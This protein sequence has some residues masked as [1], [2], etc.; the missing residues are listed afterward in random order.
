M[1]RTFVL[2]LLGLF[3]WVGFGTYLWSPMGFALGPLV[4][5]LLVGLADMTQTRHAIRRNFPFI[6]H[7]RYLLEK[8]RPE[9][10]QYFVESNTDGRPFSRE[11]RSVVYQRAKGE[12][13]TVPFGTQL[14]L[15]EVGAE[16]L[17]HSLAPRPVPSEAP[18]IL[19]GEKQCKQP[20]SA[21]MLNVSAMSYGSLSKNAILALSRGAKAGGFAHNTGEGGVSDYHREGGADL[22]WQLGTG[23]F[24]C[25]NDDGTF[26][27]QL[28][29]E[30]A[31]TPQI[32]MIEIKLSQGAKP[33]HGG[34]LPASKLTPEI[35]R[36]RRVKMGQDVLS[37][38]AHSAFQTPLQ[39]VAFVDKL[40]EL[41]GGKPVGLKICIGQRREFFALCKAMVLTGSHPDYIQVDGAEGGTGAAPLEFSNS[42]GI[43]LTDALI[44][45]HNALVGVGLRNDIKLIASGKVLTGFNMARL[46]AMGA[47]MCHSARA[48]MMALGCIQ[49][50][51]CNSND[52][53]TGVAT[54]DPDLVY[55]L[56]VRDKAERVARY[57]AETMHSF[58]E[59]VAACGVDHPE[60]LKPRNL[61]RRVSAT[62]IRTYAQIYHYV[63]PG[64]LERG[65]IPEDW[66]GLWDWASAE[67]FEPVAPEN[68][69]SA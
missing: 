55:G 7:A 65:E 15:Y 35:A 29:A 18:R 51:R 62:E 13:D 14:D 2:T 16:W 66:K 3:A 54:Q 64:C 61:H 8:V 33:A 37:P 43:P 21:S 27:E 44:F 48:M 20:Y 49:A 28:F 9:I 34:I 59:L 40:R 17:T 60:Q 68:A 24:G 19:I 52:C 25:R 53:P 23:Y 67:T 58:L 6:G 32:K 31:R 42:L 69:R 10:N 50:R 47:D 5:V 63:A 39:L 26:S 36:I 57:H 4:L 56:D 1:R 30:T 12:L 38:P 45:V 41:S 11:L 22:I 46:A